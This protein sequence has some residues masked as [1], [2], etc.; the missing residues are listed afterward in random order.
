MSGSPG[1]DLA[2]CGSAL[3]LKPSSLGDIVH[4][5]PAV[6]RIQRAFPRLR[7]RWLCNEEWT[8][9]LE[10]HP[11]LAGVIPFPRRRFRGPFA[12]P[13]LVRW[14]IGFRRSPR[15]LPEVGLDFQGLL[16]SALLGVLRGAVPLVGLADAREGAG[17]FHRYSVPVPAG[18]HAVDRY[19]E[20]ARALGAGGSGEGLDWPLPQGDAPSRNLP[21]SFLLLHP[22]SRGSGKSLEPP[23]LQALCDLL[24]PWPVVVAGRCA[25]PG[26]VG[27]AHVISVVNETSIPQLIW[28]VRRARA[29]VSVDSGPMHIAAALRPERTLAIHTWSDPRRVG[30]YDARARVWKAGRIDHRAGFS[31]E[32][33]LAHV[34]FSADQAPAVA[35]W[36][37]EIAQ[38]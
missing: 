31:E 5:L 19:L 37:R 14:V 4:T 12:L 25:A 7:L 17:W 30:P 1:V 23:A 33:A 16:R 8:P 22:Y 35:R 32:E 15:E 24:A 34:G 18:A 10:G 28:L 29:I 21:D 9:L 36:A 27:G 6:S 13:A 38:S 26:A 2:R 20:L 11:H 3:I